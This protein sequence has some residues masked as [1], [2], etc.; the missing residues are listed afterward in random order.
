MFTY[1]L[2]YEARE[3]SANQHPPAEAVR[4]MFKHGGEGD[5]V[6]AL[7]LMEEDPGTGNLECVLDAISKSRS[8]LEQYQALSAA[9][10]M[11]PRLDS[12]NRNRLADAIRQQVKSGA[13]ITPS[14]DR[15]GLAHRILDAIDR[16]EPR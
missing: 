12:S 3:Y 16:K 13:Y 8:A 1:K 2:V 10:K 11:V 7:V 14:T 9:Y 5:R 6:Y 15:W 4:D